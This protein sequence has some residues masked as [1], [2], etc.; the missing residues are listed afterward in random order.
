MAAQIYVLHQS[1]ASLSIQPKVAKNAQVE[2]DANYQRE[3]FGTTGNSN[4][5]IDGG[6]GPD[7]TANSNSADLPGDDGDYGVQ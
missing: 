4:A 3:A 2:S 1:A 6:Y 7:N 5:G